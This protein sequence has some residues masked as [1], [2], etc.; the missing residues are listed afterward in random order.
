M[1]PYLE[2]IKAINLSPDEVMMVAAHNDDLAAAKS[3]GLM[4]AFIPRPTEH[5]ET[6]SSDLVST[7]PWDIEVNSLLEL[8]ALFDNE[9]SN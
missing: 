5:G 8:I 6:Q 9:K 7:C 3:V 1:V 4:T 2:S